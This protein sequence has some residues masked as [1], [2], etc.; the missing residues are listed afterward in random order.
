VTC[1]MYDA[2]GD[3][4]SAVGMP[5]K[6]GVGGG[7]VA[8]LPGQLGIGVYSPLL[9]AKG[10]SVRGV[11]VCRSLSEQ[12]G[13]HFLTVSRDSR[14]SL[15]AIYEPRDGIRVYETHGDLMFSGVEQ[16]V[17]TID[18]QRDGIDVA[19]LDV[20]RVDDIDDVARALLA[21][22][23][24]TLRADGKAGYLVDPDGIVIRT[25]QEYEAIRF[26]SVEDAVIAAE[27]SLRKGFSG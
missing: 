3:W 22:A 21:G 23:C 8:V 18:R 2:A 12:L 16:V 15:R 25:E 24:E 27:R 6:S 10:N 14:N 5:A 7:I 4:V 1:G 19:I 9:D 26:G 20:S 13:L 17:R 11:R